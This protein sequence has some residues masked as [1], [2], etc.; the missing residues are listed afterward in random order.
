MKSIVFFALL[1]SLFAC[2]QPS[3]IL[4]NRSKIHLRTVACGCFCDETRKKNFDGCSLS[5]GMEQPSDPKLVF[6]I[7]TIS[8]SFSDSEDPANL[9][10]KGDRENSVRVGSIN[11]NLTESPY[12]YYGFTD[13]QID[14]IWDSIELDNESNVFSG[15]GHIDVKKELKIKYNK[16]FPEDVFPTQTIYFECKGGSYQF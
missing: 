5:I 11:N 12:G 9:L 2:K 7:S 10:K 6:R 8:F 14:I 15:Y 4:I 1:L 16:D 13:D 3:Q